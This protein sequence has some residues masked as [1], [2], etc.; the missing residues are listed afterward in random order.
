MGHEDPT[1]MDPEAEFWFA[2]PVGN[3][4]G[5]WSGD[6]PEGSEAFKTEPEAMTYAKRSIREYGGP[7]FIIYRC[8]P[9]SRLVPRVSVIRE[10]LPREQP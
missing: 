2:V 6:N 5:T 8:V 9:V 7:D 10:P 4:D 1:R 3:N